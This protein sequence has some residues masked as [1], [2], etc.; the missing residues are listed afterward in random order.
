MNTGFKISRRTSFFLTFLRLFRRAGSV[1]KFSFNLFGIL[2]LLIGSLF[3]TLHFGI[4]RAEGS[5]L[6]LD[7]HNRVGEEHFLLTALHDLHKVIGKT[8]AEAWSFTL[9]T[10]G[11]ADTVGATINF[12]QDGRQDGSTLGAE[13]VIGGAMIGVAVFA[14]SLADSFFFLRDVVFQFGFLAFGQETFNLVENSHNKT[15]FYQLGMRN[16]E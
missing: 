10:D 5:N 9:L 14:E 8:F 11:L 15:P 4:F 13:F 16:E 2:L 6:V 1:G 7:G 3:V 12:K